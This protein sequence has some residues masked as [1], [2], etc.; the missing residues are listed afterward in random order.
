MVLTKLTTATKLINKRFKEILDPQNEAIRQVRGLRTQILTP[1]E[2][3]KRELTDRLMQWREEERQRIAAE[4]AKVEA[5]NRRLEEERL[6]EE[7]RRRKIQA[8]HAAKGHDT[9][10]LAPVPELEPIPEPAPLEM[11]DTTRTRK[12][13]DMEVVDASLV[14][15]EY[16]LIDEVQIRK[17]VR[18]AKGQIEIPGVR[19]FQKEVPVFA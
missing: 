15:E 9:K 8:S 14:P 17:D 1:L 4:R 12:Q 7:E 3:A 16:R 6:A 10:P 5:E 18:S 2:D 13:W 11:Q 19:V